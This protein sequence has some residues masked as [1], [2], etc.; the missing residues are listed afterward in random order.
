[1]AQQTK[2][3][4]RT[5]STNILIGQPVK[6]V[7]DIV[8]DPDKEK[9]QWPVIPDSFEGLEQSD[10]LRTDTVGGPKHLRQ[11]ITVT[12]FD[13]GRFVVPPFEFY[14]KPMDGSEP[15]TI[16]TDSVVVNVRSVAVDTTQAFKPIYDIMNVPKT[17][18]DYW[19][20]Y[21]GISMLLIAIL[22]Y[23]YWR[24]NRK[25]APVAAPAPPPEPA[26]IIALRALQQLEQEKVWQS[27]DFKSY[28][29][30]L[31][32]IFKE[33][34]EARFGIPAVE[35]TT[36]EFLQAMKPVTQ[37][38]QQRE[39]VEQILRLAD[40]V[41]FAKTWPTPEENEG[42]MERV[43][44]LIEWTKPKAEESAAETET[45]NNPNVK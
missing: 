24:K 17:A 34:A 45:V 25:P 30:R 3:T 42:S 20:W 39:K 32:E 41:K 1:M 37:L 14:V 26:H 16:L 27:G 13:S 35:Q 18:L 9:L 10:S 21:L 22:A 31:T 33:Y 6:V 2:I 28:Y 5:D 12:G 7:L 36:E 8:T 11:T 40:L 19:P 43:K 29:S 38:N 4:T 44:A 15:Y 23:M